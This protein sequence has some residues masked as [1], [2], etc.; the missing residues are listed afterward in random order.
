MSFLTST[1]ISVGVG[2][3]LFAI[4]SVL[5]CRTSTMSTREMT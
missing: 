1:E 4:F 5:R 2:F 3:G